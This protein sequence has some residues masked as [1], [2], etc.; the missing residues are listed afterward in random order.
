MKKLS[1]IKNSWITILFFLFFTQGTEVMGSEEESRVD[2]RRSLL[3]SSRAEEFAVQEGELDLKTL[4]T[5]LKSDP[6]GFYSFFLRHTLPRREQ[7]LRRSTDISDKFVFFNLLISTEK[8]FGWESPYEIREEYPI[9]ST[10]FKRSVD[11]SLEGRYVKKTNETKRRRV[12]SE[13]EGISN[14]ISELKKLQTTEKHKKIKVIFRSDANLSETV[15][16]ISFLI[17]YSH[18]QVTV[19]MQR[20]IKSFRSFLRFRVLEPKEWIEGNCERKAE[21]TFSNLGSSVTSDEAYGVWPG[22]TGIEAIRGL[23]TYPQEIDEGD[24]LPALLYSQI[25][26]AETLLQAAEQRHPL[27]FYHLTSLLR[28]YVGDPVTE[29]KAK[30]EEDGKTSLFSIYTSL[31]E[32]QQNHF[33]AL[34]DKIGSSLPNPLFS[35]L[36]FGLLCEYCSDE[37]A[38]TKAY[39]IAIR[40]ENDESSMAKYRLALITEDESTKHR[41]LI[42]SSDFYKRSLIELAKMSV[43]D[44]EKERL[45]RKACLYGFPQAFYEYGLFLNERG[46]FQ[47]AIDTLIGAKTQAAYDVAKGIKRRH[48]EVNLEGFSPP[49][50]AEDVFSFLNSNKDRLRELE[51]V[52]NVT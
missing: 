2:E 37:D 32:K 41:L 12:I 34:K 15:Y 51:R 4:S 48:P 44:A 8:S 42:E 14:E 24:E 29:K 26:I 22:Q 36:E 10:C 16:F 17:H 13:T 40:G 9:Q 19:D 20:K 25:G 43:E 31:E 47:N 7:L 27:A 18:G 38:A 1:N 35:Y 50:E 5:H 6:V 33:Q 30:E 23:Y 49:R 28:L 45:F 21:E 3:S 39:E 52:F 11:E 46:Q